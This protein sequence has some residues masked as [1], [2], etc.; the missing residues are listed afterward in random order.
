MKSMKK[1]TKPGTVLSVQHSHQEDQNPGI[2]LDA[3]D[4]HGAKG[5]QTD[6]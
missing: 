3:N 4:S 5:N 1:I 6:S 2:D